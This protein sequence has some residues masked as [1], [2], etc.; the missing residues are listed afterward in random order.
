LKDNHA[1]LF[2]ILKE[3]PIPETLEA[4]LTSVLREKEVVAQVSNRTLESLKQDLATYDIRIDSIQEQLQKYQST[5]EGNFLAI[6]DF[7]SHRGLDTSD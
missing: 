6:S 3:E 7:I 5:V 4:R 2:S 1:A